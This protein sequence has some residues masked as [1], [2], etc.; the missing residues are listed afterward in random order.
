[1]NVEDRNQDNKALLGFK[2]SMDLFMGAVY[3]AVA[4]FVWRFP[5]ALDQFGKVPVGAFS[6]LFGA[7]GVFRI[8]RGWVSIK[9]M[10][11]QRKR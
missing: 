10:M 3:V 9:A 2:G 6:L 5:S 8:Y 1:M 11:Q 4:G 7:Y